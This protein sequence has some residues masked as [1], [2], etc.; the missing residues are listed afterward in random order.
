MIDLQ[1]SLQARELSVILMDYDSCFHKIFNDPLLSRVLFGILETALQIDPFS[2]FAVEN[3]S[4]DSKECV[5]ICASVRAYLIQWLSKWKNSR[6][7]RHADVQK[8]E[9]EAAFVEA[10]VDEDNK[11]SKLF[12]G[13]L[14]T[15]LWNVNRTAKDLQET[16]KE[17]AIDRMELD[18]AKMNVEESMY[19][20]DNEVAAKAKLRYTVALRKLNLDL[21]TFS[22]Q[23]KVL[24][25]GLIEL[26]REKEE[27]CNRLFRKEKADNLQFL[28]EERK[29]DFSGAVAEERAALQILDLLNIENNKK[30]D[31]ENSS[32]LESKVDVAKYNRSQNDEKLKLDYIV[33]KRK[34]RSQNDEKL[35]LDYIVDKRK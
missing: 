12:K 4:L 5:R 13:R 34:S 27:M 29:E 9:D 23:R 30:K 20:D 6:T 32:T 1:S 21:E 28:L 10:V 7:I 25:A 24:E 19:F 31:N 16:K 18:D 14:Q 2:A 17:L 26:K 35:K 3:P 22:N 33:D 11:S 15:C 8:L